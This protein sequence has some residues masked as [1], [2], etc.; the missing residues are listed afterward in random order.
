MNFIF[1]IYFVYYFFFK[2]IF[3][4]NAK[5]WIIICFSYFIFQT[6]GRNMLFVMFFVFIFIF[7]IML[8]SLKNI[9]GGQ[10]CSRR[11]E[12]IMHA[13]RFY[14]QDSSLVFVCLFSV[15]CLSTDCR[16]KKKPDFLQ[17]FKNSCFY[18]GCSPRRQ[19]KMEN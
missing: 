4:L 18:C 3:K 7:T 2:L 5:I 11:E 19:G 17:A 14:R 16:H 6:K 1:V 12:P 10:L 15:F 8:F 9:V 13:C